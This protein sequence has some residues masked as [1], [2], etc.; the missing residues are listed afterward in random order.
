MRRKPA[1]NIDQVRGILIMLKLAA[2]V[3]LHKVRL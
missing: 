3:A 1:A 2:D